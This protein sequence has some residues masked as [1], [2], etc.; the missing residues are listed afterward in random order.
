MLLAD[1]ICTSSKQPISLVA[2]GFL[3][4]GKHSDVTGLEFVGSVKGEATQDDVVFE[5]KLQGF[6]GLVRP[7]AVTY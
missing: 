3:Q 4:G 7:K 2:I 5:I 1:Y 6:E